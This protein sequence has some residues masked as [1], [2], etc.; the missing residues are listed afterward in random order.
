MLPFVSAE[1]NSTNQIETNQH[2]LHVNDENEK[3]DYTNMNNETKNLKSDHISEVNENNIE[4]TNSNI[5]I[6]EN[7]KITEQDFTNITIILPE[8]NLNQ[9]QF[10]TTSDIITADSTKKTTYFSN[11]LTHISQGTAFKII[12]KTPNLNQNGLTDLNGVPIANKNVIF[13]INNQKYSKITDSSGIAK[14]TI[15]LNPGTYKLEYYF[16]GD[17]DYYSTYN[18]ISLFVFKGN[19]YIQPISTNVYRA[20]Q[21][22]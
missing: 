10:D 1:D 3:I 14:L 22:K 19:T 20:E 15:N 2:E 6:H 5:T 13:T 7:T 18:S 21:F 17:T 4:N 9:Y 8:I 11:S 16:G 12:L